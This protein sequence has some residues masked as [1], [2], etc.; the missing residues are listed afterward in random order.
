LSRHRG[1]KDPASRGPASRDSRGKI[2][3]N[4]AAAEKRDNFETWDTILPSRVSP[5]ILQQCYSDVGCYNECVCIALFGT[6]CARECI[7]GDSGSDAAQRISSQPV[8]FSSLSQALALFFSLPGKE[9]MRFINH[10]ENLLHPLSSIPRLLP[11]PVR[12]AANDT[13]QLMLRRPRR[14]VV[15][16]CH[17][18]GFLSSP[19]ESIYPLIVRLFISLSISFIRNRE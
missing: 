10:R 5:A 19:S 14:L 17:R 1:S 2:H 12:I 9:L 3:S 16:I 4:F 6:A 18:S 13:E 8:A 11:P 7:N 15:I